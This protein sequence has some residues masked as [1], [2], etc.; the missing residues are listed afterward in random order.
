[1][2]FELAYQAL[3]PDLAVI[4]PWREWQLRSREDAVAYAAAHG[5]PVPVTEARPYSMDQNLLHTSYEGGVLEDPACPPP[6]GMYEVTVD[7]ERAPDRPET[8]ELTF[9]SGFPTAL[10]GVRLP[11]EELLAALNERAA[12][13]GVGR[14]DLVENRRVGVKSRGAYETPGGTVLHAA[15]RDLEAITLDR[16]TAHFAAQV[17]QRYAELAYDGLWFSPLREGLDAFLA[18]SHRHVSGTVTVRLFKGLALPVARTAPAS[19]YRLDLATF[20]DDGAYDHRDA[21]GFIRLW[22]LPTRVHAAV[23]PPAEAEPAGS[24][25]LDALEP[26]AV[27]LP[28]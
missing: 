25:S 15:L 10:D 22:G 6:P 24:D 7:P 1:V 2:R 5:V 21:A 12:A 19:L 23:H 26:L 18:A 27:P 14:V 20:G 28:A 17:A 4:A 3:A 16:D 9:E 13:H 11:P 8:V